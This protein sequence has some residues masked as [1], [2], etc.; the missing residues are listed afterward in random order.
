MNGHAALLQWGLQTGQA[1]E[2]GVVT[3]KLIAAHS[4]LIMSL[5]LMS[6]GVAALLLLSLLVCLL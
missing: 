4:Q 5:V 3:F 6:A 2:L 1:N